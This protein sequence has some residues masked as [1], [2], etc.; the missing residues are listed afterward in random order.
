MEEGKK[1]AIMITIIVASLAAAGIITYLSHGGVP[2][3]LEAIKEGDAMVWM[4]C[5][6]PKCEHEWEM[7]A[8]KYFNHLEANRTTGMT[9]PAVTCPKCGEDSGYI[10]LKCPKC[11]AVFEKGSVP[12]ASTDKCPKCGYSEREELRKKAAAEQTTETE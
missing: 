8:R 9:I 7:D 10:G 3:S 12:D 2:G 6:N 5:R 1:K 4:K 11:G